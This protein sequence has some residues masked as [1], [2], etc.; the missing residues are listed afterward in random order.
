MVADTVWREMYRQP[1]KYELFEEDGTPCNIEDRE[2]ASRQWLD[3]MKNEQQQQQQEQPPP[4][5]S[6]TEEEHNNNNNN[7]E[8][9]ETRIDMSTLSPERGVS[10]RRNGHHPPPAPPPPPAPQPGQKKNK[11]E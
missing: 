8:A 3:A 7:N 11:D 1:D 10:R 9:D 2:A 4:V 5:Q 6:M